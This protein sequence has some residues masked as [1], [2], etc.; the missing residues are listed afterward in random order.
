MVIDHEKL[1][2]QVKQL[3]D[4]LDNGLTVNEADEEVQHC[5]LL[6]TYSFALKVLESDDPKEAFDSLPDKWK[7]DVRMF[8]K[9]IKSHSKTASK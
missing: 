6:F 2:R 8:C 5:M 3:D 1:A 9:L 7:D 4:I